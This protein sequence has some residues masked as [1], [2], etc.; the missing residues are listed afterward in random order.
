[1]AIT[2]N[3]IYKIEQGSHHSRWQVDKKSLW[4]IKSPPYLSK[5]IPPF[6]GTCRLYFVLII[7]TLLALTQSADNPFHSFT[8]FGENLNVLI[9]SILCCFAN[10]SPCYLFLHLYR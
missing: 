7:L 5:Y 6:L 9:S 10:V 4:L 2:F 3:E 1:M 8:V